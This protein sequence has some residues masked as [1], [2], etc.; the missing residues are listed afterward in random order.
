MVPW[1]NIITHSR[2]AIYNLLRFGKLKRTETSTTFSKP[3]DKPLRLTISD[4]FRGSLQ[5]PVSISGRIHTGYI[6]QGAPVCIAPNKVTANVKLITVN[7]KPV[8]WA[9]AGSNVV[10]HLDEVDPTHVR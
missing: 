1:S 5:S 8:M 3:V 9:V 2:Y 6:Q 7:K 10:M 4:V